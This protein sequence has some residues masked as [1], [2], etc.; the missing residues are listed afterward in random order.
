MTYQNRDTPP[1]YSPTEV[2]TRLKN[3]GVT[4]PEHVVEI[5]PFGIHH[6]VA[7][8]RLAIRQC[9]TCHSSQSLLGQ[10][11]TL[12][13][14]RDDNLS[15]SARFVPGSEIPEAYELKISRSSEN[16]ALVLTPRP[17]KAGFYIL[18][19]SRHGWVDWLGFL[20]FMGIVMAIGVH[21]SF[22][23]FPHLSLFRGFRGHD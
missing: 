8:A 9:Q 20:T 3:V 22:R 1:R 15:R 14:V 12:G 4:S 13:N 17:E 19:K 2:A 7:P 10:G 5:W 6:D 16:P 23:V 21:A 18:G 11:F